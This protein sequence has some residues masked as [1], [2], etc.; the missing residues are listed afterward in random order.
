VDPRSFAS[1][2]TNLNDKLWMWDAKPGNGVGRGLGSYVSF[3]LNSNIYS[4]TG[5]GFAD[6]VMI[7][8]GQAFFV[9]LVQVRRHWSSASRARM[10][11]VRTR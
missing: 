11:T 3:D 8:S 9:Q 1:N 2:R 10:P 5:N 4:V 7:Q 6:N